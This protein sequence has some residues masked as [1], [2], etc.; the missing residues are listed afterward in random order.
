MVAT[1]DNLVA[2]AGFSWY[3]DEKHRSR[4]WETSVFSVDGV[5]VS[6]LQTRKHVSEKY[7]YGDGSSLDFTAHGSRL[8]LTVANRVWVFNS[9]NGALQCFF[10]LDAGHGFPRA[11]SNANEL[12][13]PHGDYLCVYSLENGKAGTMVSTPV[14]TPAHVMPMPPT[15]KCAYNCVWFL[16]GSTITSNRHIQKF[17]CTRAARTNN[18]RIQLWL[19]IDSPPPQRVCRHVSA[20]RFVSHLRR[21]LSCSG[22][23]CSGPLELWPRSVYCVRKCP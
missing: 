1:H 6:W 8:V 10:T 2:T 4:Q 7:N 9:R 23:R 5:D 15:M 20:A 14:S 18:I 16:L 11:C 19:C 13:V 3:E 17:R 21:T 12:I 22:R